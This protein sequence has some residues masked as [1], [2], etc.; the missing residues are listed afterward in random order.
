[1]RKVK[2]IKVFD[3]LTMLITFENDEKRVFDLEDILEMQAFQK[4]EDVDKFKSAKII[5]GTVTW[6]N[7][8]IDLAPQYMYEISYEFDDSEIVYAQG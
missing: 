6:L 4:L 2:A 1:M 5:N 3:N 7:G 8:E